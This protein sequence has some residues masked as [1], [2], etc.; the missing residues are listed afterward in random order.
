MHEQPSEKITIE[1]TKQEALVLF[2]MLV[3]FLDGDQLLVRDDAER[4]ALW[5]LEGLLEKHLV[6]PFL[7]NYSDL[8]KA[9][10]EDLIARYIGKEEVKKS[11]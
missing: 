7:E 6:E 3:N 2:E 4:A 9:A 8:V 10:K 1:F 11:S 5:Q